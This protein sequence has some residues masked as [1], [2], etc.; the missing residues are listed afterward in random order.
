MK[1]IAYLFVLTLF[2]ATAACS[3][4]D[5]TTSAANLSV[6]AKQEIITDTWVISS[7]IDNSKNETSDFAGYSFTFTDNGVLT[8]SVSGTS[9]SGTWSIGSDHSGSDDSGHH[10]GDDNKLIISIS[11]NYQMDELTDDFQIVSISQTEI[12][13]KDDNLTKVKE[14][15]FTKK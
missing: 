14:L 10:S 6:T 15:R 7:Y 8:A 9:Y 11:G 4:T 5:D 12:V 2:I 3:K 1:T 13:L